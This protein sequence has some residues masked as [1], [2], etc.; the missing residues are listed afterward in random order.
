MLYFHTLTNFY[1]YCSNIK[2]FSRNKKKKMNYDSGKRTE[3]SGW[4]TKI[5][6][7][8]NKAIEPPLSTDSIPRSAAPS[9]VIRDLFPDPDW[10]LAAL[11]LRVREKLKLTRARSP[12]VIN[13]YYHYFSFHSNEKHARDRPCFLSVPCAKRGRRP[14]KRVQ[15]M[16]VGGRRLIYYHVAQR[17]SR[18][19]RVQL[20]FGGGICLMETPFIY[21]TAKISRVY[22]FENK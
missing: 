5:R 6:S 9:F 12:R 18:K 19:L 3:W 22:I 14:F 4:D 17:N 16:H 11:S 8:N 15:R 20:N 13:R 7:A 2:F 1:F 21:N 10:N